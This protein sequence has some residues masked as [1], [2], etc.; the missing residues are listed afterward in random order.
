MLITGEKE[1]PNSVLWKKR[2]YS[3]CRVNADGG[4]GGRG[5]WPQSHSSLEK[6]TVTGEWLQMAH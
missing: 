6:G 5:G 3:S 4:S 2:L 1:K